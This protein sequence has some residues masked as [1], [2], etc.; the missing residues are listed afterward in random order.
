M[1]SRVKKIRPDELDEHIGEV[2]NTYII[3][4]K[5]TALTYLKKCTEKEV[6]ELAALMVNELAL[7]MDIPKSLAKSVAINL[8]NELRK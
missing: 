3:D 6:D 5:A 4:N 8:L 1:A 2:D 7:C